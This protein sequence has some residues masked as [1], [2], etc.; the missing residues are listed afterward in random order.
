MYER[1]GIK[2]AEDKTQFSNNKCKCPSPTM[3]TQM[4]WNADGWPTAIGNTLLNLKRYDEEVGILERDLAGMGC[5]ASLEENDD[6]C[7]ANVRF[8]ILPGPILRSLPRVVTHADFA[9]DN[10]RGYALG[11]SIC[12]SYSN[13]SRLGPLGLRQGNTFSSGDEL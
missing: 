11:R 10:H 3:E 4:K 7:D 9:H 12:T 6:W 13:V 1:H 8:T 2:D 5:G